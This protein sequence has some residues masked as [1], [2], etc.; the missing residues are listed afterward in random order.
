MTMAA[1]AQT[2]QDLAQAYISLPVVDQTNLKGTWNFDLKWNGRN[3]AL[4]NGTQRITVFDAIDQQL[5]LSLELGKAPAPVLVID[6]VNETPTEDP[7]GVAQL[8]PPR[9]TEFEVASV[10]PSRPDET[11]AAA[12]AAMDKSY[13]A[14]RFE[15]QAFPM[16]LLIATA[17][18]IGYQ[19][20]DEMIVGAPK[21][22]NSARFDVL[23]KMSPTIGSLGWDADVRLM[24][25]ALLI[26]RFRMKVHYEDR[27]V[28]GPCWQHQSPGLSG[29]TPRIAQA[30]RKSGP[31]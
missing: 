6:H 19:Y 11:S 17:W 27:P 26:D 22:I 2:L 28:K 7:T 29:R 24:L 31:Y 30:A 8:L 13:R 1:F 3:Q 20:I 4:P 23:A 14:G 18:D 10:K 16:N 9:E 5:G 15:V 25:R 12:D 21:W